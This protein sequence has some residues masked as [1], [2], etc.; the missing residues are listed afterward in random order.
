MNVR[1]VDSTKDGP[2][3]FTMPGSNLRDDGGKH[4]AV[5]ADRRIAIVCERGG[6][7]GSQAG[8]REE[9]AVSAHDWT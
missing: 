9:P 7:S 5:I 6:R 8:I 4:T 1:I 2:S 3:I